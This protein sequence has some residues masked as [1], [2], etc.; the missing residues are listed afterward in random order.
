[1]AGTRSDSLAREAVILVLDKRTQAMPWEC[2]P[3][4]FDSP[5]CRAP[6]VHYVIARGAQLAKLAERNCVRDG[7]DDS[8]TFYVLNP[9][10]DL[11]KSQATLE[12]HFTSR[13]WPGVAGVEPS[14]AFLMEHMQADDLFMYVAAVVTFSDIWHQ[15]LRAQCRGVVP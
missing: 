4:L 10:G 6:S 5:V 15:L 7:V 3:I 1:M 2:I 8:K 11:I 12:P 14:Q 13:K 9:A